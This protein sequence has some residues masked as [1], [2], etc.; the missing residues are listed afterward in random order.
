MDNAHV[1]W[2]YR[3][4][5]RES[6]MICEFRHQSKGDRARVL[7]KLSQALHQMGLSHEMEALQRERE[8]RELM[9]ALIGNKYNDDDQNDRAYDLIV[10]GLYR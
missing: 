3:K 2:D 8:A 1:S 7:H 9:S 4:L 10:C 5:L 6:L